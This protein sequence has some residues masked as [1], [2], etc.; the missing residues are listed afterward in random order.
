[1][2]DDTGIEI[3]FVSLAVNVAAVAVTR[4]VELQLVLWQL[5]EV[6]DN[7]T[8]FIIVVSGTAGQF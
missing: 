1:M 4:L 3:E 5:V 8:K 7:L 2:F 6:Q